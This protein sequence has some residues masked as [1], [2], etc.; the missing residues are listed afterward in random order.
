M[1]DE[2][3][4]NPQAFPSPEY[5]PESGLTVGYNYGL[6]L[7]DYFAAKAMQAIVSNT[8]GHWSDSESEQS[9]CIADSMLKERSK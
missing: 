4:E 8:G 6:T 1:K 9:Y 5:H 2:K 3:P 7:R